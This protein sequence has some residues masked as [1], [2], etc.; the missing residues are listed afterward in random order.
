MGTVALLLVECRNRM[1]LCWNVRN[2]FQR[3]NWYSLTNRT[4]EGRHRNIGR[5]I[6]IQD[7]VVISWSE[8][9]AV[10]SVVSL[11][12][13]MKMMFLQRNESR[14]VVVVWWCYALCCRHNLK[15]VWNYRNH[16]AISPKNLW[17]VYLW[18][19]SFISYAIARYST[20]QRLNARNTLEPQCH[21]VRRR[22]IFQIS[23][24]QIPFHDK[25]IRNV[26]CGCV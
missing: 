26:I 16:R 12:F 23:L 11:L 24:Q 4:I 2:T 21:S 7:C 1:R 18:L 15:F 9:I 10:V 22:R 8:W 20:Y 25:W 13:G 5:S 17:W 14:L 6:R 19:L 3:F